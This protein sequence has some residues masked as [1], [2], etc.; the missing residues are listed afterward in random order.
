MINNKYPDYKLL[1]R[2]VELHN[3]AY[4]LYNLSIDLYDQSCEKTDQSDALY[5]EALNLHNE[6]VD[7]YKRS[8]KV[9]SKFFKTTYQDLIQTLPIELQ[10]HIFSYLDYRSFAVLGVTN[11]WYANLVKSLRLPYHIEKFSTERTQHSACK[12][13][14]KGYVFFTKPECLSLAVVHDVAFGV[15]YDEC[16]GITTL[17]WDFKKK[18]SGSLDFGDHQVLAVFALNGMLICGTGIIYQDPYD[19]NY[20]HL[21]EKHQREI[22]QPKKIIIY[23]VK[24][25]RI[26]NVFLA[27]KGNVN[28]FASSPDSLFMGDADGFVHSW[29]LPG[30]TN[31]TSWK[32]H[33][34]GISALTFAESRLYTGSDN[35]VKVWDPSSTAKPLQTIYSAKKLT[36]G[37]QMI[38]PRNERV[39]IAGIKCICTFAN[40]T[41]KKL[42]ETFEGK[43]SFFYRDDHLFCIN[44]NAQERIVINL[45]N[46]ETYKAPLKL[47]VHKLVL[48]RDGKLFFANEDGIHYFTPFKPK[49]LRIS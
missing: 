43:R 11:K 8:V 20:D 35:A 13:Y 10:R 32:A 24:E 40:K 12:F 26:T 18:T 3:E 28:T 23:S 9:Y 48:H 7:L 25:E 5:N 39:I 14:T 21:M 27:A 19:N 38:L 36:K 44:N 1:D 37:I 46:D 31:P 41:F 22:E 4:A 29:K 47:Q 15:F 2:S 17:K 49:Y 16:Q 6:S 42:S 30:Y 45:S 34:T 33:Q